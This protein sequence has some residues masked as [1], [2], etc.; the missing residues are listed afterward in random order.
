MIGSQE[1][2]NDRAFQHH[3]PSRVD[4]AEERQSPK[5]PTAREPNH[6]MFRSQAVRQGAGMKPERIIQQVLLLLAVCILIAGCSGAVREQGEI[7]GLQAQVPMEEVSAGNLS[8]LK[9]L[10]TMKILLSDG[11]Y[12]TVDCSEEMLA[13]ITRTAILPAEELT[14]SIGQIVFS[15]STGGFVASITI[16]LE[17]PV[18]VTLEKI[19]EDQWEII[20][21][22]G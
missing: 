7:S 1:Y 4:P 13:D 5:K 21:I 12:I 22:T 16:Q 10:P 6:P 9:F 8:H 15:P 20:E 2:W 18:E 14:Y 11:E 19:D 3:I 17:E